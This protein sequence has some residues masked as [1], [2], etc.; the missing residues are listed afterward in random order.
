MKKPALAFALG[1]ATLF[2]GTSVNAAA[3]AAKP[4][5][6]VNTINEGATVDASQATTD[7]SSRRRHWRHRHVWHRPAWHRPAW[8]RSAWAWHR[9][10]WHRP[11]VVR[12]AAWPRPAWGWE[13]PFY[14]S[15][16][17]YP[18]SFY[19]PG[20]TFRFGFGV[21]PRFHHRHWW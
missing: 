12:R 3:T 13:D 20:P 10:V 8:H 18:S 19:A 2:S 1:A 4:D 17:S 6:I 7:V 14:R 15:Y 11:V 16:G 5:R 9:P 21:A